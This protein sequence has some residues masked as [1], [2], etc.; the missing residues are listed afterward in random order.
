MFETLLATVVPILLP[1]AGTLVSVLASL[2]LVWVKKYVKTK[3]DNILVENALTRISNTT[4]TVVASLGQTVAQSLKEAA[5]DGKLT[6]DEAAELRDKA[7]ASVMAL[8][9]D[10]LKQQATLGVADLNQLIFAKIEQAVGK[11]SSKTT[12]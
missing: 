6:K 4:E 2:V 7:Y 10:V 12:G 5:V 3:T 8:L 1:G 11:H 9:P